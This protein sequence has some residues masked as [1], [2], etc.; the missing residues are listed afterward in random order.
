MPPIYNTLA[1]K[2]K[3]AINTSFLNKETGIYAE[4]TQTELA[5]PLY[6]G[7]V[8]EEDKKKLLPDYMIGRKRRLSSGRRFI[9]KQSPTFRHVR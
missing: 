4:G 6:W 9:R 8:P 1:Q 7:I 3:E 5:M 2:I